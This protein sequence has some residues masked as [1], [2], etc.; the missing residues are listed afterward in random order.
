MLLIYE[1]QNCK[2]KWGGQTSEP[3]D[4]KNGV[5]QGGVCS[6]ILFAVYIDDLIGNLRKSGIGCS[7]LGQYYGIL[8]FAD[9]IVLLSGSRNGLQCMVDICSNFV[10]KRN[11][12]FGTNVNPQK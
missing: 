7:I 4:V 12:K 10:K 9:D 2:V 1:N 5:R 3:F 6:A 11:L 8:V